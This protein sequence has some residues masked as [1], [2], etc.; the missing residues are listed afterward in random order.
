MRTTHE[1]S[2]SGCYWCCQCMELKDGVCDDYTPLDPDEVN[3][4]DIDYYNG[5]IRENYEEYDSIIGEYTD[6]NIQKEYFY[7]GK[8]RIVREN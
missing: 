8:R 5:I 4:T 6:N 2:C 3:E 1:K 7:N